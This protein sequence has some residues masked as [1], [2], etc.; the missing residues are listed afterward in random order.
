VGQ[1][2]DTAARRLAWF[3]RWAGPLLVAALIILI[4]LYTSTL[5][6]YVFTAANVSNL[7]LQAIP[8]GLAALGQSLVILLAGVDLS[9][10]PV[11][12][13]VTAIASYLLVADTLESALLGAAVALGTGIGVGLLNAVLIR[14]IRIPDL[15]ATLAT[16]SAVQGIALIVRPSPGGVVSS[17]FMTDLTAQIGPVPYAAIG[18]LVLYVVGEIFLLRSKWGAYVYAAGSRPEAAYSAGVPIAR[19]RVLAYVASGLCGALAGLFLAAQIGSGD[20]QAG[21]TFTL[22][23]ITA[24]V[25]GGASIFGGRGTLTGTLLGVLLVSAMQNDLDLL[26]VSSYV[27]YVWTGLL[28]LLAVG[29]SSFKAAGLGRLMRR[30]VRHPRPASQPEPLQRVDP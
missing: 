15:I 14:Y 22:G 26:H 27:Q 4:T 24:V 11:M 23:S 30:L 1:L 8:L 2:A 17:S 21:T 19:V 18:V 10:G 20:P 28:T 9:I 13:L 6:P 12:S 7:A 16:Y 29:L 3:Q 25:V 5:S